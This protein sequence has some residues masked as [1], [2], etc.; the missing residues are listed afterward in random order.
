[1]EASLPDE[2]DCADKYAYAQQALESAG[3]VQYEVANWARPG[4]ACRHNLVYWSGGSSAGLACSA[5]GHDAGTGTRS[6][7]VAQ[8][9]RY[10]DAVECGRSPEAGREVLEPDDADRER[11]MLG[12]RRRAGVPASWLND[13]DLGPVEA[14]IERTDDRVRVR[15]DRA[16]LTN[17]VLVRC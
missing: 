7:N 9:E 2:D 14:V 12:L 16:F 10:C 6:W 3:I 17:Q 8:P 11:L 15:Q 5:H 1:G 4:H 13:V